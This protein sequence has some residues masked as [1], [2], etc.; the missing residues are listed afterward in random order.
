M[1]TQSEQSLENELITQLQDLKYERIAIAYE[2]QLVANLGGQ[3]EKLIESYLFTNRKPRRT[4]LIATLEKKPSILQLN[5][6][7]KRL[8]AKFDKFIETFIDGI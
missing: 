1:T 3:L 8:G 5:S 4:D 2:T 6:I 7:V